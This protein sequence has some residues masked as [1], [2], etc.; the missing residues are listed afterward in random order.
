[1]TETPS[2]SYDK[3]THNRMDLIE[4]HNQSI[5]TSLAVLTERMGN[6]ERDG[7]DL[8]RKFIAFDKKLDEKF[9]SLTSHFVS[10]DEFKAYKEKVE[11]LRATN[12]KLIW[13]VLGAVIIALVGLVVQSPIN[14]PG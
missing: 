2:I 6:V 9:D 1:M 7:K 3:W 13:I 5:D 12:S 4:K 11:E 8:A 10:Q 14:F